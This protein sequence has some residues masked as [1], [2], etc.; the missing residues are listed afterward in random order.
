MTKV[1]TVYAHCAECERE[2]IQKARVNGGSNHDSLK[3]LT[4]K[5][6]LLLGL[7]AEYRSRRQSTVMRSTFIIIII[8]VVN[9]IRRPLQVLNSAVIATDHQ[10]FMTLTGEVS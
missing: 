1:V 2:E 9:L 6:F 4:I 10:M 5:Y 3:P 8:I 7:A